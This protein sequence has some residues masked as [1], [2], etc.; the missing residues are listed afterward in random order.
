MKTFSLVRGKRA[1]EH[2]ISVQE[3][4]EHDQ[5]L[6]QQILEIDLTTFSEP[7][8]TRFTVGNI[9]RHGC[10]FQLLADGEMIGTCHCVRSWRNPS[11]VALVNQ[12]IRTGWRGYG[13]GSFFL[14]EV[15]RLLQA[16]SF[17]SVVLHVDRDNQRARHVYEN[18]FG[19]VEV[20]S[21]E[22]EYGPGYARTL[23][24]LVLEEVRD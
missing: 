12:A 1:I 6:I 4:V 22:H 2:A 14:R 11:E 23:M 21:C 9:M 15:L 5:D 18:K 24:R 3:L 20:A 13:L 19:F 16:Q 7:T 10:L 8:L 17:R